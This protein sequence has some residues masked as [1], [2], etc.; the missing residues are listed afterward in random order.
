MKIDRQKK[1]V[2]LLA[3]ACVFS[4]SAAAQTPFKKG[5]AVPDGAMV[6]YALPSSVIEI[7]V[8][9]V[10]ELFTAGPYARYAQKYLGM[11]AEMENREHHHL[12]SIALRTIVEADA[13][14]I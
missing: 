7:H 8:E 14:Q 13:S 4:G 11:T 3:L 10:H 12:K 9:A 2:L 6:V 1:I 5:S